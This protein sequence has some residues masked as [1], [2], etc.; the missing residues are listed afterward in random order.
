[1]L[2]RGL[3]PCY[4][5]TMLLPRPASLLRW[6]L[7]A[8]LGI[9]AISL[10]FDHAVRPV[11]AVTLAALELAAVV[12]FVIP[13][14]LIWGAIL[15]IVV[16]ALAAVVHLLLKQTPSLAYLVYAAAIWVVVQDARRTRTIGG[17]R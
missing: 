7:A 3:L 12:L 9:Q 8:V 1:M 15:L 4:Q 6:S 10:L 11:I 14:T 16:L 13:R 2:D 17:G 5:S